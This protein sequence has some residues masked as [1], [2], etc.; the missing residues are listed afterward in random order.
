MSDATDEELDKMI[1][2]GLALEQ[3]LMLFFKLDAALHGPMQVGSLLIALY[4]AIARATI[5]NE[6][7]DEVHLGM[8]R[9]AEQLVKKE[10][11]A[12]EVDRAVEKAVG[13]AGAA[14]GKGG[15]C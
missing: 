5:G 11:V 3:R 6:L 8:R 7:T 4:G 2:E 15:E 14:L 12:A 9:E 13:E 10:R 1:R